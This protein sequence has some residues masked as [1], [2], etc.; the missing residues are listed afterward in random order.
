MTKTL[1]LLAA[2]S[3][4]FVFGDKASASFSDAVPESL[5]EYSKSWQNF[6]PQSDET[7]WF[8]DFAT[9]QASETTSFLLGNGSFGACLSGSNGSY[10]LALNEKCY[11]EGTPNSMKGEY[12][13]L[14][15]FSITN[16]SAKKVTSDFVHQLDFTTATYSAISRSGDYELAAIGVASYPD[17]V[18]AM[19]FESNEEKSISMNFSLS[20]E[21]GATASGDRGEGRASGKLDFVS[22]AIHYTV[23]AEGGSVSSTGAGISVSNADA[24]TVYLTAAT[25]VNPEK[26][27]ELLDTEGLESRMAA[28]ANAAADKGWAEVYSSHEEDYSAIYGRMSLALDGQKNDISTDKLQAGY[29][30]G[31]LTEGQ[32]RM[33]ESLV[34][35]YGR[36]LAISASRP[37]SG[38]VGLDAPSNLQGIWAPKG[39]MWN[40]DIHADIN[41]Q[42]NYWPSEV[43]NMS[44]THLPLLKWLIA[45]SQSDEWKRLSNECWRPKTGDGWDYYNGPSN[46]LNYAWNYNNLPEADREYIKGG[47][48]C[49]TTLNPFGGATSDYYYKP[50]GSPAERRYHSA[51]AW[52]C[53]HLIQHYLFTLDDDYLTEA[54][55]TLWS[56]CRFWAQWMHKVNNGDGT[57]TYEVPYEASP[58]QD[59]YGW[60]EP[61]YRAGGTAHAQQLVS[62]LFKHTIDFVDHAGLPNGATR[63]QL[64]E[65]KEMYAHMDNGLNVW[66]TEGKDYLREWKYLDAFG[67]ENHRHLSHLTAL[68][69][70]GL[71][72]EGDAMMQPTINAML[73]RGLGVGDAD[74]AVWTTAWKVALWARAASEP[75]YKAYAADIFKSTIGNYQKTSSGTGLYANL[76]SHNQCMQ[77]EGNWGL[78]AAV[79]EMLLQSHAGYIDVLPALPSYWPK[80]SVKGLKAMGN[81]EVGIDWEANAPSR[82]E[83][84]SVKGSPLKIKREL[85]ESMH[86]YIDGMA[87]EPAG[88]EEEEEVGPLSFVRSASAPETVEMP[89]GQGQTLV[90]S[91]KPLE[92]GTTGIESVTA[93]S[94]AV[95]V[96]GRHVSI[97]GDVAGVEIYNL[98]GMRFAPE[99]SLNDFELPA[100]AGSVVLLRATD[101]AGRTVVRKI[102]VM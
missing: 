52:L 45:M 50:G 36:Y 57:Y 94:L 71:V 6:T 23:V 19:H 28:R 2:V 43:T 1:R 62:Y 83:I 78:T 73:K 48:T 20:S 68:Y 3:S 8:T 9:S 25:D 93:A 37:Y 7:M 86:A 88:D 98:Q 34:F 81:F 97:S 91:T 89:V 41:I 5:I 18:I 56:A 53:S 99:G 77:M 80:G 70:L 101:R 10:T 87:Y 67:T 14:G 75:E 95:S 90:L 26:P 31:T 35:A 40:C 30:S 15:T 32:R 54:L 49:M 39:G 74:P 44:E 51:Q 92:E 4:V 55:P 64:E 17:Q 63:E 33:Y 72:T 100:T 76:T 24:V 65:M 84:V 21:S 85:L 13:G 82:V 16:T 12:K 42:M 38:G 61:F 96:S 46:V 47:W 11:F 22:Y 58:E 66:N 102:A 79:A 69:P 29:D 59:G 27:Y 60:A